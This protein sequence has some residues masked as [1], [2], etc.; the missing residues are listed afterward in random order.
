MAPSDALD[1]HWWLCLRFG[2]GKAFRVV[3]ATG[4]S[5]CGRLAKSST[6][7]TCWRQVGSTAVEGVEGAEEGYEK[8]AV[9]NEVEGALAIPKGGCQENP[10]SRINDGN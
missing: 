2:R 7:Q 10:S 5:C 6:V 3:V 4:R 8:V 9:A 1:E